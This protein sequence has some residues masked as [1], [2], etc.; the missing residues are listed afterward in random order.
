MY[1]NGCF[2]W[3]HLKSLIE[4][5]KLFIDTIREKKKDLL[6][7]IVSVAVHKPFHQ[8]ILLFTTVIRFYFVICN[9]NYRPDIY[10]NFLQTVLEFKKKKINKQL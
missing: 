9:R 7:N 1:P 8:R 10:I 4:H 2:K 3:L 5:F 6:I